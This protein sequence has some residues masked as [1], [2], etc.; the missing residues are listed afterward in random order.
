[1]FNV[2]LEFR[3]PENLRLPRGDGESMPTGGHQVNPYDEGP[4]AQALTERPY[5]VKL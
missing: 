2:A 1:M 4:E 5:L 3:C